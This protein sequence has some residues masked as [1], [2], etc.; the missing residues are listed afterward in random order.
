MLSSADPRCVPGG[1]EGQLSEMTLDAWVRGRQ[2]S[3]P[4]LFFLFS[5]TL[6]P[7]LLFSFLE[8]LLP[9]LLPI[10]VFVSLSLCILNT[11][12]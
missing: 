3:F 2:F 5:Q 11:H 6:S 8:C 9:L 1:L 7:C 4:E 12:I 10:P